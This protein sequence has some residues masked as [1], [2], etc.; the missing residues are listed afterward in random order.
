MIFEWHLHFKASRVSVEGDERWGRP[1][2]CRTTENV[3]KILELN[4]ESELLHI[5]LV[6]LWRQ[7]KNHCKLK[8]IAISTNLTYLIT[9]KSKLM[10]VSWN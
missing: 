2:T 5:Y 4:H 9:F 8:G 3:E 6:C 1:S 10:Q 7:K